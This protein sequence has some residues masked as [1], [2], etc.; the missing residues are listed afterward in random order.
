MTG[1]RPDW[2]FYLKAT[3]REGERTFIDLFRERKKIPGTVGDLHE[4]VQVLLDLDADHRLSELSRLELAAAYAYDKA[5]NDRDDNGVTGLRSGVV[6][7]VPMTE[8]VDEDH[9]MRMRAM[10]RLDELRGYYAGDDPAFV[11]QA[12]EEGFNA[13]WIVNYMA[14]RAKV[15]YGV[16]TKLRGRVKEAVAS[17]FAQYGDTPEFVQALREAGLNPDFA[18]RYV[19]L[20]EQARGTTQPQPYPEHVTQIVNEVGRQAKQAVDA[21]VRKLDKRE[22]RAGHYYQLGSMSSDDESL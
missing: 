5:C 11:R 8:L 18:A 15:L 17:L 2:E 3:V 12:V 21:S 10:R 9:K 6:V 1:R 4:D 19:L 7:Y 16:N 14:P 20:H 13:E 22:Q